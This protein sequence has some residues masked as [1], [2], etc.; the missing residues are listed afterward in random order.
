MKYLFYFIILT[1]QAFAY[2]PLK[3]YFNSSLAHNICQESISVRGAYSKKHLKF[4]KASDREVFYFFKY[5]QHSKLVRVDLKNYKRSDLSLERPIND[6]LILNSE[7]V[8]LYDYQILVV[9]RISGNLIVRM[10]TQPHHFPRG[11]NHKAS[12]I[13]YAHGNLYI[14]HG[15]NGVMVFNYRNLSFERNI[16][17]KVKQPEAFH[18]SSITGIELSADRLYLSYDD[19]TIVRDSKAFE[20]LVVYD[21]FLNTKLREIPVN[22]NQEAYYMPRL[23]F[24]RGELLVL[25]LD[26]IFRHKIS[27]LS[28]DRYMRPYQR[29]WK[30]P[31]GNLIGR[32]LINNASVYGCF[33]DYRNNYIQSDE[34]YIK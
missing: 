22:Q 19:V 11:K 32:P 13:K 5:P 26:L 2:S 12:Q 20:G 24:D 33:I 21:L 25:N 34:F 1:S 7:I 6:L 23:Q 10:N 16:N 8:L 30:Y 15:L 28:T 29:I 9:D 4:I 31:A 18:R 17:P 27:D 14:A 3:Q